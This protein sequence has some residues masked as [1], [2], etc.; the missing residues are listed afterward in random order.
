MCPSVRQIWAS[1]ILRKKIGLRICKPP[2]KA[3]TKDLQAA[4]S[5]EARSVTLKIL[6]KSKKMDIQNIDE[7]Q[8][9][10][11]PKYWTKIQKNG[12]PKYWLNIQRNGYP[13]Y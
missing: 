9:N 3:R 12:Y 7:I 5:S 6:T 13:K 4:G 10:G 8:K 2:E 1:K 11:Y